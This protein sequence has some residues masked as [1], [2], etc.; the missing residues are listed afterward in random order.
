M[1]DALKIA[2]KTG[3]I[4][5]ITAGLVAIFVAIPLPTPDFSG[6][7]TAVSKAL[8]LVAYWLPVMQQLWQLALA[9]M[10]IRIA[11]WLY[12]FAMIAVR[13]IMKVNE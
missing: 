8:A 10:G 9:L 5:I 4:V 1:T 13:W 11:I 3:L 6:V 12:E 2:V 7:Y